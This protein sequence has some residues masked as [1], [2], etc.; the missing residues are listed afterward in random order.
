MSRLRGE[1]MIVVGMAQWRV[2]DDPAA[3]L[4]IVGLGSCVGLVLYEPGRKIAAMAHVL[5][6]DSR[7]AQEVPQPAKFADTAVPLLCTVLKE[8]G[9]R[10]DLLVAKVAGGARMFRSAGPGPALGAR[11]VDAVMAALAA[12]NIP[13]LASDVG[14]TAGRTIRFQLGTLAL[15]VASGDPRASRVIL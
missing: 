12:A 2:S 9:A 3:T 14:G 8:R 4:A 6:P 10:P 5:L 7:A 15:E 1:A 13:V 11:N